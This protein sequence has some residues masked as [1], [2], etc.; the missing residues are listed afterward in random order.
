MARKKQWSAQ[1]KEDGSLVI[2]P[3]LADQ[4]GIRP[5]FQVMIEEGTNEFHVLR[6]TNHLAK[7]YI[8]ATNTCNLDCLTCMRNVWQE[9]LGKMSNETFE[10]VLENLRSIHPVPKVFFMGFGEPLAHARIIEMVRRV[11]EIGA[12]V[13]LITNGI[14]LTEAMSLGLIRAGLDM[15]WISMDG[16]TPESY[17]DVRLGA[18]L[19]IVLKNLE[20]LKT[21]RYKAGYQH[22]PKPQIGI[23]FVAM[24]RNIADL[25]EVLRIG[26]GMGIKRFSISN[27]LPH[28]EELYN[29]ILY[30]HTLQNQTV[31]DSSS[32]PVVNLPR[33]D[34]NSLTQAPIAN[35]LGRR[36]LFLSAGKEM[37]RSSDTCQFID[38]G[39][40]QIRWD[41]MVSPC[42]PLLHSYEYYAGGQLR[43]THA[44]TYGNILEKDLLDIWNDP[45]YIAFRQRVQAFDF[46][47]CTFC[48]GCELSE[49]NFTDCIDSPSPTCGGC[50]WAQGVIQCP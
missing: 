8:E 20:T 40:V 33:I 14:L 19:P 37:Y 10:R 12:Y 30:S 49:D 1:V 15:L 38:Q 41:G 28:T 39:S 45:E 27:V 7:V 11:K 25:P 29:E 24:K 13:E 34:S 21:I 43:K 23:A 4:F 3:E 46:S 16:A 31:L 36:Y 2:P 50:L 26:H 48:N 35:V 9:P 17:S 47:P 32:I 42:A 22:E 44:Y 18:S 6:P 5:G